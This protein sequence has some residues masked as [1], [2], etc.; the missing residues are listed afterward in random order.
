MLIILVDLFQPFGIE[1]RKFTLNV[2]PEPFVGFPDFIV[3]EGFVNIILVFPTAPDII[4]ASVLVN[5][6]RNLL[7]Q[8][9]SELRC[10]KIV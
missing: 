5:E 4:Y 1:L 9:S 10:S 2:S 7:M 6:P 8:M 3:S